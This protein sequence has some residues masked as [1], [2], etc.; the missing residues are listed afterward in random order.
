MKFIIILV[1]LTVQSIFAQDSE[2]KL[3]V[4][5]NFVNSQKFQIHT[6]IELKHA[7]H[8]VDREGRLYLQYEAPISEGCYFFYSNQ[9]KPSSTKIAAKSVYGANK[10]ILDYSVTYAVNTWIYLKHIEG[11]EDSVEELTIKCNGLLSANDFLQEILSSKVVV[12]K[13]D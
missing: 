12:L 5:N 4:L 9:S 2:N 1:M 8:S 13:L 11:A 6:D 3:E 7:R 10:D